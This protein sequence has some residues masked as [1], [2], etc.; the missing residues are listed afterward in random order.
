MD[1]KRYLRAQWDRV[2]AGVCVA[3]GALALLVGW[4]GMSGSALSYEQLPYLI[5]GGLVGVLL[6]GIGATIFL[7]ADLR[8]EWRK[9]DRL[10]EGLREAVEALGPSLARNP[11]SAEAGASETARTPSDGSRPKRRAPLR[12]IPSK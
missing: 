10:E 5:S 6:V 9:L 4:L 1:V 7:S 12:P 11:E 2:L 8:D 3:F